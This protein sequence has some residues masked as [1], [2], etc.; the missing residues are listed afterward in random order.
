MGALRIVGGVVYFKKDRRSPEV[1]LMF[2]KVNAIETLR[3]KKAIND[4][5]ACQETLALVRNFAD[6]K[7]KKISPQNDDTSG[8]VSYVPNG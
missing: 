3:K 1:Q 8:G 6:S 2:E 4:M 5:Q 7:S